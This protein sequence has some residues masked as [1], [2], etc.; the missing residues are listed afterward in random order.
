MTKE[1]PVDVWYTAPGH[2]KEDGIPGQSKFS[3]TKSVRRF[4]KALLIDNKVIANA[5]LNT[6]CSN[7][8]CN[9]DF[10]L[11]N[12]VSV[13]SGAKRALLP[14]NS[15]SP[16]LEK[17]LC[18][19][20]ID[21][22][23]LDA[24]NDFI[25][26]ILSKLGEANLEGYNTIITAAINGTEEAFILGCKSCSENYICTI[27]CIHTSDSSD[28]SEDESV[29]GKLY[30]AFEN[31]LVVDSQGKSYVAVKI[32][33]RESYWDL[34]EPHGFTKSSGAKQIK[35]EIVSTIRYTNLTLNTGTCSKPCKKG[36]IPL[37][38]SLKNNGSYYFK[39]GG[40]DFMSRKV[41]ADVEKYKGKVLT[42]VDEARLNGTTITKLYL[43]QI[44]E[45][46][47]AEIIF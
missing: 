3:S 9:S 37:F 13:S 39:Y 34:L 7:I 36:V 27:L 18:N 33:S 26:N 6:K 14:S 38:I 11:E 10:N 20:V 8:P 45:K 46:V 28:V 22:S 16:R 23:F 19:H 5:N 47:S 43:Q 44:K 30:I 35:K 24:P 12:T 31:Y 21:V 42:L 40:I 25:K 29:L 41:L 15:D 17:R 1:D 4:L 32:I 2:T